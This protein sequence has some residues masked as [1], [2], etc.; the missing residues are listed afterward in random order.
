[1]TLYL[2]F[3]GKFIERHTC[4]TPSL[5][6]FTGNRVDVNV[7][8]PLTAPPLKPPYLVGATKS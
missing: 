5:V 6:R 3:A 4:Q 8:V 2:R 1:M 7:N